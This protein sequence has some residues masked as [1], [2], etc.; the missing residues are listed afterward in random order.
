MADAFRSKRELVSWY[1]NR[2]TYYKKVGIGGQTEFSTVSQNLIDS[3]KKRI[4]ELKKDFI[5]PI[6]SY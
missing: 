2:L 5:T 3:T 4:K 1:E 6:N